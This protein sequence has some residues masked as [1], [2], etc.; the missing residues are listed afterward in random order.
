LISAGE[1]VPFIKT[2]TRNCA[3]IEREPALVVSPQNCQLKLQVEIFNCIFI[4]PLMTTMI[5][6]HRCNASLVSSSLLPQPHCRFARTLDS[7]HNGM[8]LFV[9]N[10]VNQ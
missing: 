8:T 1:S 4:S 9:D 7:I 2:C 6:K 5:N 10:L 3:S